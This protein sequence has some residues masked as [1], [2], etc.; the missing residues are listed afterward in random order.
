MI[1]NASRGCGAGGGLGQG[2][3]AGGLGGVA[4]RRRLGSDSGGRARAAGG[5]AGEDGGMTAD[6]P[7]YR[8]YQDLAA[9]WPLISPP[10][11]YAEEAAFAA[12][13]LNQAG[14]PVRE[15]LELG[16]GG[17]HSA[18]HLTSR[19]TMTLVD[20]SAQMIEVSERLNPGCA[21]LVADM[22]T[23]RLGRAF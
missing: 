6:Q 23:V 18:S 8:L 2:G 20:A 4:A 21:H 1:T 3:G 7:G 14:L 22:R 5:A 11:E 10:E 12:R 13:V 15:V 16:S 19:F 17:G 9:W